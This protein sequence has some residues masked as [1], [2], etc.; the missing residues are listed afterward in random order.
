MPL[1]YVDYRGGSG[2][3]IGT[4]G[5]FDFSTLDFLE[6]ATVP[7]S[8]QTKVYYNGLLLVEATDYTVTG[9]TI[10][11]IGSYADGLFLDD[12]L[13]IRRETKLNARYVDY[14]DASNLT[15]NVLDLDSDQEFFLIQENRDLIDNRMQLDNDEQWD[16]RGFTIKNVAPGVNS[17]DVPN[18]GQVS[19]MIGGGINGE[20]AEQ[21][22]FTYT[23]DGITATYLVPLRAGKTG[24]DQNVYVNGIKQVHGASYTVADNANGVD[25]DLTFLSGGQSTETQTGDGTT[26]GFQFTVPD[27]IAEYG[28]SVT[29][30]GVAQTSGTDYQV[31]L[32]GATD[33]TGLSITQANITFTTAPAL[34]ADIVVTASK[35]SDVPPE[36]SLIEVI[37]SVGQAVGLLAP[38][39]VTTANI[40][41][42]AVTPDKIGGGNTDANTYFL[43]SSSDI[44]SWTQ[45]LH[46]EM[47]DFDT[48]VRQNRLDQLAA[49]LANVSLN[50]QRIIALAEPINNGDA[51]TKR[52]VDTYGG[53]DWSTMRVVTTSGGTSVTVPGSSSQRWAGFVFMNWRPGS[54]DVFFRTRIFHAGTFSGAT[55]LGCNTSPF[56]ASYVCQ[57]VFWRVS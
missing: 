26:T 18:L 10:T 34:D 51:A 22:C 32:Q 11:L 27:G 24:C 13:R 54:G 44:V 39:T 57:G 4:T 41:D 53:V 37:Y 7:V 5:P 8:N 31:S 23:A 17:T 38:D 16:G 45:L 43:K 56:Y 25:L 14:T 29:V 20:F 46:T 30:G 19:A 47:A 40:Q 48:G 28:I 33:S 35:D 50:S 21:K 49:P 55:A 9:E 3:P 42:D 1:S 6:T 36:G 12:L 15:E 2:T 52:Y